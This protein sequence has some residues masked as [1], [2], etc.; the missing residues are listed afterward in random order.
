MNSNAPCI[1]AA[2]EDRLRRVTAHIHDHLDE[3]LDMDRLAEVAC[4]S[5]YH[6]HRIYRAVH[7][8]TP[9]MT[10]R[11]LRL[12]AAANALAR[13]DRLIREI[14]RESR[15]PNLQSFTR[16]FKAAYGLPPAEYRRS[17]GHAALRTAMTMGDPAMYD[18][19][20]R[21]MKPVE[22]VGIDHRGAYTSIGKAFETLG[23]LMYSRNLFGP[24]QKMYGVYY[25][26][27]ES[28]PESELRS[29]AAFGPVPEGAK[30]DLPLRPLEIAGG[31]YAVL[32][33]KGP[34][35]EL[36]LAY[37][38]LY[39]TWLASQNL[40]IRNEPALEIYLNTPREAAPQDLMTEICI[41]I[42]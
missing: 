29:T 26:D 31:R 22:A 15:Y 12:Q 28:V 36:A 39:R 14:A 18:V 21:D 13:T 34:Y 24:G 35:A 10:V 17:G 19:T 42:V 25:D 16:T 9:V 27:P 41:P 33:H 38:W 5:P 32:T 37:Q 4:M 20:F 7:G 6:W 3:D 30:L 11:R 23:G 8:E 40:E 1:W 2:Y